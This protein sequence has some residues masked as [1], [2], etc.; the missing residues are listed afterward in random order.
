MY[1]IIRG[2]NGADMSKWAWPFVYIFIWLHYIQQ[3]WWKNACNKLSLSKKWCKLMGKH[4]FVLTNHH[5]CTEKGT[6]NIVMEWQPKGWEKM[7][8]NVRLLFILLFVCSFFLLLGFSSSFFYQKYVSQVGMKWLETS[9][10]FSNRDYYS[11]SVS[12]PWE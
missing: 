3:I 9:W 12:L 2:T 8:K 5:F 10:V 1:Q 4:L 7:Q 6:N 11:Q